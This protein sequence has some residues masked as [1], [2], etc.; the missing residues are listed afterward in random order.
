M[1]PSKEVVTKITTPLTDKE[2][3]LTLELDCILDVKVG[4]L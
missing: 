1:M 3:K 4:N 2:G